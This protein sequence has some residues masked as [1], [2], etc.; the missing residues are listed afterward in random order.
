[1]PQKWYVLIRC[2]RELLIRFVILFIF[3]FIKLN[4]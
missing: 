4:I 2:Y 1:M 3:D